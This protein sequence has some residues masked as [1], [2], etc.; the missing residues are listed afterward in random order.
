[1]TTL[2]K[3]LAMG[4]NS[5]GVIGPSLFENTTNAVEECLRTAA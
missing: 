5:V 1:M 3:P 2:I 4:K